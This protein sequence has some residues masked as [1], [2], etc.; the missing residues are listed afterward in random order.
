MLRV[1]FAHIRP[2]KEARLR[3][4]LRE[5]G[6]REEE[7][8][9][10]FR[11]ETISHE[12]VFIIQAASGPLLVFAIEVDNHEV[13]RQVYESSTLAIDKQHGAVLKECLGEGPR[14]PPLFECRIPEQDASG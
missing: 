11:R 3:D 13:A 1:G 14:I 6:E 10:T 12:Q 7:V 8:R 4:W 9:E 2:E 5:L